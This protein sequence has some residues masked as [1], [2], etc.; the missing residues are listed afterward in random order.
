M[1]LGDKR[2]IPVLI[3]LR[4]NSGDIDERLENIIQ[5]TLAKFGET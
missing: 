2:S 3:K 5:K 1:R 4:D